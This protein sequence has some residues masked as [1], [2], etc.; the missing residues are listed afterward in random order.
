MES[1]VM[2]KTASEKK[3]NAGRKRVYPEGSV[4]HRVKLPPEVHSALQAYCAAQDTPPEDGA[5]IL[6]AVKEFLAKREFLNDA[7]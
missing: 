2:S 3:T 5:A 1:I 7:H 6:K 4:E